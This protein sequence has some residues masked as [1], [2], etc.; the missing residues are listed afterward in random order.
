MK[1]NR[2]I[3]EIKEMMF[4]DKYLYVDEIE[5]FSKKNLRVIDTVGCGGG[6]KIVLKNEIGGSSWGIENTWGYDDIVINF[7]CNFIDKKGK[8]TKKRK[9]I[10]TIIREISKF[11]HK[12][13]LFRQENRTTKIIWEIG[14][15]GEYVLTIGKPKD[16]ENYIKNKYG[17]NIGRQYCVD[18]QDYNKY[19]I[20]E[21]IKL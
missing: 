18:N 17:K 14:F 3:K 20:M 16:C 1:V 11:N 6:F 12:A 9:E 2:K 8:R 15:S 5:I 4:N 19:K 13:W 21:I 10:E 7:W